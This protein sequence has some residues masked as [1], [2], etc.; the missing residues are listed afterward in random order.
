MNFSKIASAN[1]SWMC[2]VA[3]LQIPMLLGPL[4]RW[5]LLAKAQSLDIELRESI[6]I[7]L[8]GYF[9]SI[10]VPSGLGL[11][12]SRAVYALRRC[13]GQ[14]VKIVSTLV[15]DRLIGLTS[16]ISLGAIFGGLL[17]LQQYDSLLAVFVS[18]LW[19]ALAGLVGITLVILSER[20]SN[21][22]SPLRRWRIFDRVQEALVSYR[23]HKSKLL[24]GLILTIP[25]HVCI[26]AGTY[27]AF[28]SMRLMVPPLSVFGL[29]PIVN[30]SA[31]IPL[32]PMGLGVSE[33]VASTLYA[34]YQYL[35]GADV[36]MALRLV[37]LV[38]MLMCGL[39]TLFP[40]FDRD[41]KPSEK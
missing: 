20:F 21:L 22:F 29:T 17:L 28:V 7:G 5:Y 27:F 24:E 25:G 13:P 34:R 4:F 2:L 33:W 12:G 23:D 18:I 36:N 31:I 15:M 19:M 32:T 26:L 35:G 1:Q 8:I 30:L 40:V 16:M 11:D 6:H 38:L 3:V 39:A 41:A 9:A 10:F 14:T 37:T